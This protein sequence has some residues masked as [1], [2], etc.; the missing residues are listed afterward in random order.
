MNEFEVI[1]T[2]TSVVNTVNNVVG[3]YKCNRV[4]RKERYLAVTDAI[5]KY[6]IIQFANNQDD[7]FNNNI[8]ILERSHNRLMQIPQDTIL[9]K[10]AM[11]HYELLNRKLKS[12]LESYKML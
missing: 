11:E 5:R 1:N 7:I 8:D 3:D 9:F 12:L 10:N 6:R 2:V 4:V